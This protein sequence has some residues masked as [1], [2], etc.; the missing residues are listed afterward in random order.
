M[1]F[2]LTSRGMPLYAANLMSIVLEG[3]L[4]GRCR[5]RLFIPHVHG[6]HLDI[7]PQRRMRDINRPIAAVATLLFVLSTVR[8]VVGMI[9][10]EDG[11]V[12]DRDTFNPRGS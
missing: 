12:K 7:H 8:M 6:Y 4:Y 5:N 1:A 9:H 3:I 10:V 2:K 11:L